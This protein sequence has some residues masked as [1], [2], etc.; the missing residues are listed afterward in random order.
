MRLL[1]LLA[2]TLTVL[3]IFAQYKPSDANRIA[4]CLIRIRQHNLGSG[5]VDEA[6]YIEP[7]ARAHVT[8]AIFD[9]EALFA[10]GKDVEERAEIASGL[11]RISHRR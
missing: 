1:K 2:L 10:G 3:P 4:D 7:L 5:I 8:Q 6:S 9:L 11:T